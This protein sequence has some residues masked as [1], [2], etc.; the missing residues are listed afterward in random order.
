MQNTCRS[1]SGAAGQTA[2]CRVLPSQR[3]AA[4]QPLFTNF[5][6]RVPYSVRPVVDGQVERMLSD[7]VIR[8][9][10][11]AWASPVVLVKKRDGQYR[12]CVDLNSVTT[13]DSYPLPRVDDNLDALGGAQYFSVLDLASGYWQVKMDERDR[14]KTAFVCDRG[15]Y[16]LN[17]M[18]FGLTNAPGTFQR[19]MDLVLVGIQGVSC[20]VYLDDVIVY[21]RTFEEHL[22][23]LEGVVQ[24]L[25]KAGLKLQPVKCHFGKRVVVFR[26][27][28]D[29]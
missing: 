24:C 2:G 6:R 19:L 15:L 21:S 7:G 14:Q 22:K 12:L 4:S 11:S 8:P 3:F 20:L 5:P 9:S 29:Q 18:P 28:S 23:K 25:Q 13:K 10:V 17:V 1:S 26:S 16:E 27:H